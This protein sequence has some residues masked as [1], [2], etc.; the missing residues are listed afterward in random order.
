MLIYEV[1]LTVAADVASPFARW[2]TLHIQEMLAI[3]GFCWATLYDRDHADDGTKRCITVHYGV[4][5]RDQLE[6]YFAQ[7]A[8]RMRDDGRAKFGDAFT[9]D[10]RVLTEVER[11]VPEPRA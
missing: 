5:D 3:D 11:Y 9:A 10:R 6:N 7:H 2:L 8:A 4:S 1:N